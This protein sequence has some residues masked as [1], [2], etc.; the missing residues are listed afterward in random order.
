MNTII[1]YNNTKTGQKVLIQDESVKNEFESI[2]KKHNRI[3]N[4]YYEY[5]NELIFKKLTYKPW[6]VIAFKDEFMIFEHIIKLTEINK[7]ISFTNY[8]NKNGDYIFYPKISLFLIKNKESLKNT[9]TDS[10]LFSTTWWEL[11]EKSSD[12]NWFCIPSSP[13]ID[14][15]KKQEII[16]KKSYE[17]KKRLY[18]EIKCKSNKLK[19]EL[20]DFTLFRKKIDKPLKVRCFICGRETSY[21]F[22][23][24]DGLP[25][26]C[27]FCHRQKSPKILV[28]NYDDEINAA[29]WDFA[30]YKLDH[31]EDF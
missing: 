4:E 17:D 22:F 8:S 16:E 10:P 15:I 24:D 7:G 25:R 14:W 27:S 6:A 28:A 29:F 30:N 13:S 3:P 20:N 31:L 1:L 2:I 26:L 11:K 19:K 9:L 18:D 5:L 23:T 21:D 12:T